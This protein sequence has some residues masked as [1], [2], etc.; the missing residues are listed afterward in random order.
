MQN[1]AS[2]QAP[3]NISIC[4][5]LQISAFSQ[6]YLDVKKQVSLCAHPKFNRKLEPTSYSC[7]NLPREDSDA[8]EDRL[9][10]KARSESLSSELLL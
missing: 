9:T 1:K 2:L 8:E 3:K 7:A 6:I 5:H 10:L 4:S